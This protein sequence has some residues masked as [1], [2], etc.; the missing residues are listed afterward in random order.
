MREQT[1]KLL[2]LTVVSIVLLII[3]TLLLQCTDVIVAAGPGVQN[4]VPR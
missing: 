2:C 3:N 4:Y 1:L